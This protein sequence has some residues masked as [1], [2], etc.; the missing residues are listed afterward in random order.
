MSTIAG[1]NKSSVSYFSCSGPGS[2]RYI[3]I[4]K[5]DLE[6]HEK[7][8]INKIRKNIGTLISLPYEIR[9]LNASVENDFHDLIE[10]EEEY[11]N[12]IKKYELSKKKFFDSDTGK[13]INSWI[14]P[15]KPYEISEEEAIKKVYD[16]KIFEKLSEIGNIVST[17]IAVIKATSELGD[18]ISVKIS[19]K[20][21]S[22]LINSILNNNKKL[23]FTDFPNKIGDFYRSFSKTGETCEIEY[24]WKYD[25]YP[26]YR[27]EDYHHVNALFGENMKKIKLSDNFTLCDND[28]LVNNELKEKYIDEL[29]KLYC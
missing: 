22:T 5:Y 27:A 9:Q 15:E 25:K 10:A 28:I 18:S 6:I 17:K 11:N 20:N 16:T 3:V 24:L 26:N 19:I 13:M 2:C 23:S 7:N 21:K 29:K 8:K 12:A 14:Y 4:P 1:L